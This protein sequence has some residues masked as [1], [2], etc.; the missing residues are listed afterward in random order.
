MNIY[1][2]S[3][4]AKVIM[5]IAKS[6]NIPVSVIIDDNPQIKF[7]LDYPVEHIVSPE[8]LKDEFIMAI[9]D[10]EIRKKVVEGFKGKFH[11]AVIHISA[12]VSSSVQLGK[13]TVVMPNA[14]VNSESKIGMHCI[15]NTGATVEHDC[16]LGNFVHISPNAALAGGVEVEEG[17]QIGIGA[18]VIPGIKIGKWS[19]IGAG[20]VIID[21]IP[22]YVVV[23]GNPGRIIKKRVLNYAKK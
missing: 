8:A 14:S 11:A 17:T 23:V 10:N 19:T 9:G 13:G 18:V 1:G 3:G 21:D 7:V 15:I 5:D 4:H 12:A 20:A 16:V 22:D 2:A 6:Q